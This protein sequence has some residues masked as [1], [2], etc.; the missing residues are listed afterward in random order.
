MFPLLLH[1]YNSSIVCLLMMLSF[2]MFC[3]HIPID[4]LPSSPSNIS[5]V[6]LILMSLK[7]MS[8]V[9]SCCQCVLSRYLFRSV[10]FFPFLIPFFLFRHEK[11]H[12]S[13]WLHPTHPSLVSVKAF[14]LMKQKINFFLLSLP[15]SLLLLFILVF[16]FVLLCSL[17]DDLHK[18]V[19][20]PFIS[21]LSSF[22]SRLFFYFLK[23]LFHAQARERSCIFFRVLIKNRLQS[24]LQVQRKRNL[25]WQKHFKLKIELV[26]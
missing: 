3:P 24:L 15:I 7:S 26:A 20:H 11:M 17:D 1:R 9:F 16:L 8:E 12:Y 4:S 13:F 10:S 25:W 2:S 21:L 5:I 6:V 14:L 19:F 23:K 22:L 18:G